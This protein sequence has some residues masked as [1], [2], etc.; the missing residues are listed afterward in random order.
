[1]PDELTRPATAMAGTL[2]L[3]GDMRP[4]PPLRILVVEDDYLQADRLS[5]EIRQSGNEL[6][7]PFRDIHDAMP[8]VDSAQAAILDV[9]IRKETSFAIADILTHKTVPFVFLTGYGGEDIPLRFKRQNI[10]LKP[11]PTT[12]LIFAL[13]CQHQAVLLGS[14]S[15]S[16][17]TDIGEV[18][19]GLITLAGTIM[20][21]QASAERLVEATIRRAI[22]QLGEDLF[23]IGNRGDLIRLLHE[24][25][26]LRTADYIQ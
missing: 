25:R 20:P 22:G 24:E 16:D 11:S 8:S 5:S 4:P 14:P 9:R 1:M 19:S 7:G 12:S 13:R 21:D 26:R 15:I 17:A 18:L 6:V 23:E 10:Y 2:L 3:R